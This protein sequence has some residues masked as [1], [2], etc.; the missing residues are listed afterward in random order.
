MEFLKQICFDGIKKEK[1]TISPYTTFRGS[2]KY[3]IFERND[4]GQRLFF[5]ATNND[6]A[7]TLLE[8]LRIGISDEELCDRLRS[9]GEEDPESWIAICMQKGIIEKW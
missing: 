2:N 8:Q 4:I 6:G 1:Y 9:L 3:I 5:L 7:T